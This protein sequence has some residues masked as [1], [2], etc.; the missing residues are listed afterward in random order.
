MS[1]SYSSPAFEYWRE[2]TDPDG[3]YDIAIYFG[4]ELDPV[5]LESG[6]AKPGKFVDFQMTYRKFFRGE[7][8]DSF[9]SKRAL[10]AGEWLRDE[11]GYGPAKD[12]LT[13]MDIPKDLLVWKLG[14]KG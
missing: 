9:N 14:E 10:V 4:R 13:A 3:R 5:T 8:I 6:D 12:A 2:Y 1:Y 7:L 11:I